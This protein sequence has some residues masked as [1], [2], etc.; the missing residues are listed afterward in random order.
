MMFVSCSLNGMSFTLIHCRFSGGGQFFLTNYRVIFVPKNPTEHIQ[1]IELPLLFIQ[2]FDVSQP[3]LGANNLHGTCKLVDDPDSYVRLK[4]KLLFTNGGMGTMV[5]LFFATINYIRVASRNQ[6]YTEDVYM[7]GGQSS[8]HVQQQQE[9]KPAPPPFVAN[10]VVDPNDPTVV[11]VLAQ[12]EMPQ[13]VPY[14]RQ[15]PKFP[16]SKKND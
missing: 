12:P 7:D 8:A 10:A 4:W 14:E 16:T 1:A 11:Y 3:I 2:D 6:H 9:E 13:D 15:K 5:P